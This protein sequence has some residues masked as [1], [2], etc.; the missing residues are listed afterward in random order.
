VIHIHKVHVWLG[1]PILVD[2]ASMDLVL[3][4]YGGYAPM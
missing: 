2:V 1:T 3:I 4:D